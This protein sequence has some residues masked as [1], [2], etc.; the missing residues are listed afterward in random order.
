M[1]TLSEF[2]LPPHEALAARLTDAL[3]DEGVVVQSG[4]IGRIPI[5]GWRML[6]GAVARYLAGMLD[7]S[8]LD[9]LVG[10][11]N[12]SHALGQQLEKSRKSPDKDIF[13]Q[14]AEHKITSK[15]EPYLALVKDGQEIGR[16]PFTVSVEL[17]LQGAVLRIRDGVVE[18]VQ[19]GRITGKGTVKCGR[20]I[21]IEKELQPIVVPGVMPVGLRGAATRSTRLARA[22]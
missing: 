22:S 12:K 13:L 19:T 9:V 10:A 18:E 17:A 20:A 8:L 15:H 4:G 21:L 5:P 11:W 14:L 6:P 1:V 2:L 16:L 3:A 7:I